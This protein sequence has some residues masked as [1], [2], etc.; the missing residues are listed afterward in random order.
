[1]HAC[2]ALR[3]GELV[4]PS[5]PDL[6]IEKAQVKML[7]MVIAQQTVHVLAYQVVL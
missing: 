5:K 3:D 6:V 4:V 2:I 7:E 1:V